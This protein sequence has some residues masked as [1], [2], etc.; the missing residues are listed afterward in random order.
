MKLTYVHRIM[1]SMETFDSTTLDDLELGDLDEERSDSILGKMNKLLFD[2]VLFRATQELDSA[3][4]KDLEALV[5]QQGTDDEDGQ[6][7]VTAFLQEHLE[8]FDAIQEEES[9]DIKRELTDEM[10]YEQ[11]RIKEM[12]EDVDEAFSD[13]GARE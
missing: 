8:D 6:A 10:E 1:T 5:N 13:T 12:E 9:T 7:A 3:E 2:R 4:L 11:T